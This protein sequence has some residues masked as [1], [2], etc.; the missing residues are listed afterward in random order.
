MPDEK[1]R[2]KGRRDV[3]GGARAAGQA[4]RTPRLERE[5]EA[6]ASEE[7]ERA[8]GRAVAFG[9]PV[10]SLVGAILAG[11]VGSLGSALLVLAAGALVGTIAFLWA[12]VRT[13]SGDAPLA[14]GLELET[15]ERGDLKALLEEKRRALRALKDLESE[16]ALGKIDD[17][18]YATFAAQYRDEA[19]RILKAIDD[20]VAPYREKAEKMAQD[21]LTKRGVSSE[22]DAS[23]DDAP[24]ESTGEDDGV[25]E[26][27]PNEKEAPVADAGRRD[28]KSCGA[29]NEA[30]AAF[31][32]QCGASM[33]AK[34]RNEEGDVP[35]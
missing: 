7:S 25:G 21:Y 28:C 13:L 19:K 3:T 24:E 20:L 31:C 35:A 6:R 12:S 14:A 17:E 27:P 2:R 16:H 18:D 1:K 11:V 10:V 32:K 9:I 26:A 5:R 34:T 15:N 23:E 29:S 30:D 22:D 4:A 33:R 8:L